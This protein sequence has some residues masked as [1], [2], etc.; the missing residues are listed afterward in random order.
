MFNIVFECQA[1]THLRASCFIFC[2]SFCTRIEGVSYETHRDS[3]ILSLKLTW[4]Y[5]GNCWSKCG[6]VVKLHLN[7]ITSH[8][9]HENW[10]SKLNRKAVSV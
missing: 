1:I 5:C 10:E 3:T 4:S 9:T 8:V 2:C 7:P 6:A